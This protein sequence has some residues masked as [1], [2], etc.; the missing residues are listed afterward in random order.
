MSIKSLLAF[1]FLSNLFGLSSQQNHINEKKFAIILDSFNVE[2]SILIYNSKEDIYYSN[3]FERAQ[4]GFIPASTFKIPNSIIGL[5]LG[6]LSD[7]NT[8]FK[9]NGEKRRM[10][11][12]EKDLT[13]KEAFKVSCVPCYQELATKIGTKR[14][15]KYLKKLEYKNMIFNN[16]T[17]NDF[18]LNGESKISQLQQIEFL[19]KLYFSKLPIKQMTYDVMKKIMLIEKTPEYSLSGKTGWGVIQDENIGWY[20]GYLEKNEKVYFFAV[21]VRSTEKTD[22]NNFAS[23]RLDATKQAFK[24]LEI[25]D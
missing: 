4:Q 24:V 17:V 23:I 13:L 8:V 25:I 14:M 1:L 11:V 22:M 5:E 7:E 12:W 10:S 9:W 19:S 15:K 21:N 2:G 20:V 6:I 3:D 16:E 18:W